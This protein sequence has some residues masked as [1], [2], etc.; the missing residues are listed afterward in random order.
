MIITAVPDMSSAAETL[1]S[2]DPA[3]VVDS[4]ESAKVASDDIAK[5]AFYHNDNEDAVTVKTRRILQLCVC[6][7]KSGKVIEK[8]WHTD[9]YEVFAV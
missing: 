9:A 7:G 6:V 4:L 3:K 5:K 2:P 8:G 1:S